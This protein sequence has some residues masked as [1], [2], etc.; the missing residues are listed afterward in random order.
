M[1][2]DQEIGVLSPDTA[3]VSQDRLGSL[4]IGLDLRSLS[5]PEISE[6]GIGQY[7]LNHLAAVVRKTPNWNYLLLFEDGEPCKL[8]EPLLDAL[9]V[10][11]MSYDD[12]YG[13]SLDL[14]HIVDLMSM[15]LH[16]ES[17]FRIAPRDTPQSV[18]FY[19]LIPI[20]LPHLHINHWSPLNQKAYYRR[21]EQL[22]K[23]NALILTISEATKRDLHSYA[24]IPLEKMT[25]IMAGLNMPEKGE[26]VVDRES[27]LEVLRKVG[28]AGQPFFLIVGALD[29][30]KDP[31]TSIGGFLAAQ[32]QIPALKLVIVGSF[33]DPNKAAY[34]EQLEQMG[35][36][37]VIFT[38]FLERAEMNALYSS[39]YGLIF[40]SLYEG[41]GFPVLEAMAHKCPVITTDAASLPEVAGDAAI[42][43]KPGDGNAVAQAILCLSQDKELRDELKKRGLEQS[44]K[45]T[46]DNVAEKTIDAWCRYLLNSRRMLS[47]SVEGVNVVS[48]DEPL[49]NFN[50]KENKQV[51]ETQQTR[52]SILDTHSSQV[53]IGIDARTLLYGQN[54]RRGIGHYTV[55]HLHNVIAMTPS[56]RYFL[57]LE[58]E[59]FSSE[60]KQLL[61]FPNVE[62]RKMRFDGDD[63]LDIYHIPDPLSVMIGYDSPFL[64]APQNVK[65]SAVFFDLTPLVLHDL[66]LDKW[67]NENK[68]AYLSRI[69]QLQ[70]AEIDLLAISEHSAG[71]VVGKLGI[72]SDR[73]HVIYAGLNSTERADVAQNSL[74]MLKNKFGL[75]DNFFLVVGGIEDHKNFKATL[76]AHIELLKRLQVQLVVVG[77]LE[78]PYKDLFKKVIK[79][80]G[81]RNVVFTGFLDRTELQCLYRSARALVSPSFYEGFG[82]PALEAM[83]QGCPVI[84]GNVTSLPEVVGD[85]GILIE[86]NDISGLVEAMTKVIQNPQLRED[87]VE[88]GIIQAKKFTWERS[89]Q[90]TLEAWDRILSRQSCKA[91]FSAALS[92]NV[93]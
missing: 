57:Y 15:L 7:T 34:K 14:L 84:V 13:H 19:D 32:Q 9:N 37:G 89:A 47:R 91:Q 38:G 17:P 26:V 39:A 31:N 61:T 85:A 83:A 77:S 56:W 53:R 67:P 54:L 3:S 40:T 62:Y 48:T 66:H 63:D 69:E 20:I 51:S 44:R 16:Y 30:H 68:S 45:F 75:L 87:M 80:N 70:Q 28:V 29:Q 42:I 73:V 2:N 90:L 59:L 21:L 25:A 78:D 46:W 5:Y 55:N 4:S 86:P 43:V 72:S 82:F 76:A 81:I 41:F 93:F 88:R 22:R 60:I 52:V 8:M 12:V 92:C 65:L 49:A 35:V 1:A 71:D 50:N 23:S 18:V 79:E 10:K 36:S 6:R 74:A 24:Q 64:L 33:N 11:F 58:R 27:T